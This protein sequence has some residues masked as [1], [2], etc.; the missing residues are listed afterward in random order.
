[1]RRVGGAVR[2]AD[3]QG[4]RVGSRRRVAVACLGGGPG[5][6]RGAV[7]EVPAVFGDAAVGIRGSGGVN[8]DI[9]QVAGAAEGS[10]RRLV[11]RGPGAQRRVGGNLRGAQRLVVGGDFVDGAVEVVAQPASW[12]AAEVVAADPPVARVALAGGGVGAFGLQLPVD[13]QLHPCRAHRGR[14]ESG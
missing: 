13:V 4:D 14:G 1:G 6:C 10:C 9:K 5:G 7:A 8:A 11:R 2:V 12:P 3:P